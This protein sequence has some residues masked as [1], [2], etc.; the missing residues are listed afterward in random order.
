LTVEKTIHLSGLNGLRAIAALAVVVS[1]ITLELSAFQLDPSVLGTFNG[2]PKG[3]DLAGYGVSI[4]FALS[5]FL[6]TY[7][8]LVEKDKQPIDVKKF[9]IRRILRIWPIYYLYLALI[10]TLTVYYALPHPSQYFSFYVFFMANIPAI[11]G[12]S[13]PYLGHYWSLAGEEQFYGFWVWVVK[14][15]KSKLP[16]VIFIAFLS[17][18]GVKTLLHFFYPN[19]IFET[20]IHI[21]RFQCMFLGAL[22][23]ILYKEENKLFLTVFNNKIAQFLAWLVIGLLAL[24]KY[25][26]ISALDQEFISIVAVVLIIGQITVKNRIFN[27]ENTVFDFLGKISYGIYIW[28]PLVILGFSKILK[29]LILPDGLKYLLVYCGIISTTIGIAYLSFQY[30]EKFFLTMKERFSVV[31]SSATTP[32]V[33]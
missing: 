31:S 30:V 3:L 19:S 17:L 29:D 28:H 15:V 14:K 1:H 16:F 32:S 10:Y 6:I 20:I 11:L 24:N 22:G 33:F 2:K 23:A 18:F 13:L 9:Y 26:F 5:G 25:H 27:L 21:T 8:L 4:F 12:T 7:L